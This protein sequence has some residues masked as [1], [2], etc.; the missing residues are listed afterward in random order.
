[1]LTRLR[2]DCKW[3][4][5]ARCTPNR[6]ANCEA[7]KPSFSKITLIC[8]FSIEIIGFFLVAKVNNYIYKSKHFY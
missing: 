6:S 8:P 2:P 7:L 5:I 4:I 1:M 3:E